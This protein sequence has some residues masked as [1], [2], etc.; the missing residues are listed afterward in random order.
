MNGQQISFLREPAVDGIHDHVEFNEYRNHGTV[1]VSVWEF[2]V[3]LLEVLALAVMY[4][5]FGMLE[6]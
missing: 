5:L 6:G 1:W 4:G 2:V 3:G